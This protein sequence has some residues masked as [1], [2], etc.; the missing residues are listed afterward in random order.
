MVPRGFACFALSVCEFT[1][2]VSSWTGRGAGDNSVEGCNEERKQSETHGEAVP[3]ILTWFVL[4]LPRQPF[5]TSHVVALLG[6]LFGGELA[7]VSFTMLKITEVAILTCAWKEC[8]RR[9]DL[10]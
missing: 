9:F 4:M 5:Y 6:G 7:V 1:E 2:T 3:R 10:L 8:I